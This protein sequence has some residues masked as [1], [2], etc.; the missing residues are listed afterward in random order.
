[1]AHG[2]VAWPGA[3]L[4]IASAALFGAS[5]PFAKLLLGDGVNPWLLAG[6]LYLGSGIGLSLVHVGR[7]AIG[8]AS[9][10][11][12]L[13]RADLPW[14][15]LVVL[16]GGVIG[17]VLLMLGSQRGGRASRGGDRRDI[18]GARAG[19]NGQDLIVRD[20]CRLPE[21]AARWPQPQDQA[22]SADQPTSRPRLSGGSCAKGPDQPRGGAIG[23]HWE[24]QGR[25]DPGRIGQGF[26]R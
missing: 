23:R 25:A 9:R 10:E 5:T 21:G 7:R 6:L 20:L 13:R 16:S 2:F 15:G 1:M 19:R 8:L 17:P 4:A 14:L 3:P 12:T 11:A 26:V 18:R 22:G 24:R